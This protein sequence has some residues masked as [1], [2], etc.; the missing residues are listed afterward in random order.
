M[1]AADSLATYVPAIPMANPTSAFLR[2]GAS[3]VPS[4]VT[5]TTSPL[6]LSPVTSAYLSYG[7]D[8][9]RTNNL[10]LILSNSSP[11]EMVSILSYLP[12]SSASFIVLAQSH[13]ATLHFLQTTPPTSLINSA[14]SMT[15]SSFY[16]FKMPTSLAIAL[17]VT[18]LSPVTIL[19]LIP[20]VWH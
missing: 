16:P 6:S 13:S 8:L 20:A 15:N 18:I 17:A 12:F 10:S 4:P 1:I 3:F 5:A 19:T 7:L 9:A 11:L 14:P 2:A